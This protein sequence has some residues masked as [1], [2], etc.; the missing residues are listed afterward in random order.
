MTV[1][2][3]ERMARVALTHIAEPGDVR[4]GLLVAGEGPVTAL[5]VVRNGSFPDPSLRDLVSRWSARLAAADPAA[6]LAACEELGGRVVCPGDIEW[7]SQLDDLGVGRP[8]ALWVR[9]DT[10]LRFGCLRSVS[11]VGSRAASPYGIRVASE[12]AT[13]LAEKGWMVVSGG[14]FGI[15]A[16]V[17]RGVLGAGGS[18]AAVLACGIDVAYPRAH[19]GLFTD[20][21]A[22]GVLVSEVPP[23]TVPARR[24]FLVRN[25]II[26]ALTRGTVVVEAG[27]RSGATNT[28]S[29]ARALRRAVMVVPGPVTSQMSA[30]CHRMLRDWPESVLVTDAA[31]VVDL[32]GTLGEEAAPVATEP[33]TE[34]DRLH[35]AVQ[36]VLEAIPTRGGASIAKIAVSAGVDLDTALSHLGAL[37]AAGFIQR[38]GSGWKVRR[39]S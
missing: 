21:A 5:E 24:R 3:S 38:S 35:P 18:T 31:E 15:D 20:I 16:A 12:L 17:H 14:A 28:A 39:P 32:V 10:D 8:H 37:A 23:G 26:A 6:S 25:R 34:F 30:G 11:M 29:H 22:E 19:L 13:D 1:S 2:E 4:L 9:G 27:L 33:V 7:P 36:D